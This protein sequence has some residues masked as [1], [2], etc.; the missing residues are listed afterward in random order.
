MKGIICYYSG[1]GNTKL[2]LDYIVSKLKNTGF[3]FFDIT[4]DGMPDFAGY[5]IAGFATFTDFWGAP[6]LFF[7]FMKSLEP[8]KSIPAFVFST[9]GLISGKT[10]KDIADL[11]SLQGFTVI[12]GHALHTPE[13]FPPLISRGT[14]S[15]EFPNTKDLEKFERFIIKL[16]ALLEDLKKGETLQK[17]A[18]S[19]GFMNAVL[20]RF[21][22]KKAKKDMG[23]QLIDP[24]LCNA[25]GIC[26]KVCPYDAVSVDTVPCFDHKKCYGCWACFNHCP[27]KA[28]Y[29]GKV[30]SGHYPKPV[31]ALKDKLKV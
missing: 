20:P 3:D 2:A 12:C 27:R 1:S 22:R 4:K 17:S 24:S 21:P 13:N 30:T 5:D 28:I 16:S 11:A 23:E 26:Q 14:T 18:V 7:R 10:L 25:C 19:I 6:E 9:Y 8:K 31:Q 29:T 15:E